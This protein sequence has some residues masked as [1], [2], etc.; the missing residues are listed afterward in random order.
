V[1]GVKRSSKTASAAGWSSELIETVLWGG[2]VIHPD[3]HDLIR[4][5]ARQRCSTTRV[6]SIKQACNWIERNVQ[7]C[8]DPATAYGNVNAARDEC[9]FKRFKIIII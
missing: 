6:T 2:I 5:K 1:A 3:L 7:V 9:E 4:T 8:D